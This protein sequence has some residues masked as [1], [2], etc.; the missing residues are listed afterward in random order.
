MAEL[1]QNSLALWDKAFDPKVP[2]PWDILAVRLVVAFLLGGVVALI[3]WLSQRGQRTF[4][5]GFLTTLVLLSILIAAVTQVIGENS[6]RAFSLV[7]AL[8]IIRFR[9]VVEDTRDTAFV[10]F[11]V[12]VGMSI[13]AGY[14]Y[15]ALISM[16][17]VFIATQALRPIAGSNRIQEGDLLLTLRIALSG[18]PNAVLRPLF[19]KYLRDYRLRASATTRQGAALELIYAV[20]LRTELDAVALIRDLNQCEGVQ[21]V[22]L[23]RG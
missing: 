21:N 20:R 2:I 11:A 14:F 17:C 15:V 1:W 7:G 22:E 8:A 16:A 19:A 9:T 18:D 23:R 13:G 5:G 12:V 3:Y 6:A 4:S 10:I